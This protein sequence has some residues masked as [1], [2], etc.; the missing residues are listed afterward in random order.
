MRKTIFILLL[1][2]SASLF[3]DPNDSN[4]IDSLK[5]EIQQ[6]KAS[7][8]SKNKI[9]AALKA[10]LAECREPNQMI[11]MQPTSR[12]QT[13]YFYFPLKIGESYRLGPANKMF[14]LEDLTEDNRRTRNF[15][16]SLSI[17]EKTIN[18]WCRGFEVKDFNTNAEFIFDK[19]ILVTGRDTYNRMPVYVLQ[20]WSQEIVQEMKKRHDTSQS[21]PVYTI[22]EKTKTYGRRKSGG[23]ISQ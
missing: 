9:I 6:L 10:D 15:I 17:G 12:I 16:A 1:I 19:P 20:P 5:K 2:F 13:N 18:V 3:A 22:R 11:P 8:E 14:V 4:T 21:G 7:I 23:T